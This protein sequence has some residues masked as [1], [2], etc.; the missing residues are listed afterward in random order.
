[1]RRPHLPPL[2]AVALLAAAAC[3][4]APS[5]LAHP[6][7]VDRVV[8]VH[9]AP[10]GEGYAPRIVT[11]DSATIA[12]LLQLAESRG[13][14][15]LSWHPLPAGAHSATLYDGLRFIAALR[16]SPGF[17]LLETPTDARMRELDPPEYARLLDLTSRWP[18]RFEDYATTDT[19]IAAAN[20]AGHYRFG[21][22]HTILDLRGERTFTDSLVDL[23]CGEVEFHRA[24][25][26]VIT[27][28][29]TAGARRGRCAEGP[30]RYFAWAEDHLVELH[31]TGSHQ[32][33]RAR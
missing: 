29:D 13:P 19:G 8:I 21:A 12:A 25:G 1:M 6:G 23:R 16:F 33:T 3:R 26:L 22:P 18:P 15:T 30:V 14:W 24:S 2:V 17:L 4:E 32:R 5:P 20:F 9:R 7:P 28:P 10:E 11:R 31:P 27:G